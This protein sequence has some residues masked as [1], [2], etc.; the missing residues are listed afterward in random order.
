[1]KRRW[2]SYLPSEQKA[3][4][5]EL[6][7]QGVCVGGWVRARVVVVVVCGYMSVCERERVG[8][9]MNTNTRIR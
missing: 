3:I 9:G 8:E 5:K 7:S 2:K 1:M 6:S 4:K